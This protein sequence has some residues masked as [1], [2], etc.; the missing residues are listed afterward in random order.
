MTFDSPVFVRVSDRKLMQDLAIEKL[1]IDAMYA[2]GKAPPKV[3]STILTAA[4]H[5]AWVPGAI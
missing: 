4:P 3:A 1:R 2:Q 5:L